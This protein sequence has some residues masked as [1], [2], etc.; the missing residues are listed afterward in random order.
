MQV[1]ARGL[2]PNAFLWNARGDTL[3]RVDATSPQEDVLLKSVWSLEEN[4]SS[5]VGVEGDVL[6][7]MPTF[8]G[9][10]GDV[11]KLTLLDLNSAYTDVAPSGEETL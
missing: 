5:P 3:G 2:R 7:L 1:N 8:S 9:K 6:M 11:G 10:K 4:T